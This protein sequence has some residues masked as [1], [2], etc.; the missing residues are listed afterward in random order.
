MSVPTIMNE[1]QQL[2]QSTQLDKPV[3]PIIMQSPPGSVPVGIVPPVPVGLAPGKM[4]PSV[5]Q[6]QLSKL[7]QLEQ[8]II[9]PAN[10]QPVYNLEYIFNKIKDIGRQVQL[11]RIE[12]RG[13]IYGNFRRK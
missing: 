10:L 13:I 6:N 9:Q 4:P 5:N 7:N 12:R 2:I 1:N 8:P 3:L 11:I